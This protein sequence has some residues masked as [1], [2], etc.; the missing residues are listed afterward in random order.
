MPW[1]EGL[2]KGGFLRRHLFLEHLLR[3]SF[4]Q[5]VWNFIID[6]VETPFHLFFS[7]ALLSVYLNFY[8]IYKSVIFFLTF[9]LYQQL[10]I[11]LLE[12]E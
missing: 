2:L 10:A 8:K 12:D 1:P 9:I 7:Q 4:V 11:K 5:F 3:L 6:C